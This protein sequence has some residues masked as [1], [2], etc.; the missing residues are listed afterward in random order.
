MAHE[1]V[2]MG[3]QWGLAVT[4]ECVLIATTCWD[5]LKS[6]CFYQL[7]NAFG[8]NRAMQEQRPTNMPETSS[9]MSGGTFGS[10]PRTDLEI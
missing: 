1:C 2:L 4:A 3:I 9:H 7:H 5:W 10:S 8:K 6:L